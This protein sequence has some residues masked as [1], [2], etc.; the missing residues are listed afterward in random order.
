MRKILNSVRDEAIA[1][2]ED[3]YMEIEETLRDMRIRYQLTDNI[4]DDWEVFKLSVEIASVLTERDEFKTATIIPVWEGGSGTT[5][6]K[7]PNSNYRLR[8]WHDYLHLEL[9]LDF[10]YESEEKVVSRHMTY[11]ENVGLSALAKEILFIELAGQLRFHKSNGRFPYNQ[12][13][14][15]DAALQYGIQK[16]IYHCRSQ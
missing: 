7:D 6:Y 14:F 2:L 15:I 10:S 3:M 8:L 5:P 13:A 16:A 9:D 4:L 12:A 11:C 1:E